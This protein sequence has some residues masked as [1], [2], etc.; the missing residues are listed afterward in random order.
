MPTA[1]GVFGI[2]G[3]GKTTL[4]RRYINRRPGVAT[5]SGG[6]LLQELKGKTGEELRQNAATNIQDSQAGLVDA[7]QK[8]RG[9]SAGHGIIFDGHTVIDTDTGIVDVPLD[10]ISGLN[11][12]AIVF[13]GDAPAVIATRRKNDTARQRPSR[14]L[15]TLAQHQERARYLAKTYAASLGI[16]FS[17]VS[18]DDIDGFLISAD[19][20]FLTD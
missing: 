16:P 12:S 13:V 8:F 1:L 2:S 19:T 11:L 17:E 3:V 6:R 4:I 10:V 9:S 7:F 14:T 5:T 15:D 18:A 20:T